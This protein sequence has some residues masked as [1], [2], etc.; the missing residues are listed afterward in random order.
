LGP[1]SEQSGPRPSAPQPCDL[2]GFTGIVTQTPS[3]RMIPLGFVAAAA[4]ALAVAGCGS[5]SA[6][7][8]TTVAAPALPTATSPA[9][10]KAQFIARAD[11]ICARS[12][13]RLK[14]VEQRLKGLAHV[15]E[16]VV[17]AEAPAVIRQG[18][19]LTR[20]GI[21]QLQALPAPPGDAATVAKIITA[22]NNEA[23]DIDNLA[24]A[25]ASGEGSAV[26]AAKTAGQTAKA[27]YR[28]LAQGYGLKVCGAGP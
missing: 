8:T 7:T 10:S 18:A 19:K 13:V 16:S 15:S 24:T 26:E 20:E 25:T 4:A 27:T 21:A 28:G 2:L 9:T 22:L 17:I 1:L 12:K 5:G 11:A 14:P 3:C 6:A 23:A